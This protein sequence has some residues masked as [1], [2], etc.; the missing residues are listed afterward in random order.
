MLERPIKS[1]DRR[2]RLRY[3]SEEIS[4]RPDLRRDGSRSSESPELRLKR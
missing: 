4:I 2:V 1:N 3:D